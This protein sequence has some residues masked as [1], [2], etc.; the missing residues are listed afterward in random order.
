MLIRNLCLEDK[1]SNGARFILE[2]MTD[3][4]LLCRSLIDDRVHKFY[5]KEFTAKGISRRQFPVIPGF[6]ITITRSQGCTLERMA[7]HLEKGVFCHGALFT[8][9]SRTRSK[10]GV[11]VLHTKPTPVR[12][13][14]YREFL[15]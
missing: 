6:A 11:C 12:N 10:E 8:A 1:L 13:V 2:D 14:V 7:L 3:N 9:L 15:S 4:Y 5:R